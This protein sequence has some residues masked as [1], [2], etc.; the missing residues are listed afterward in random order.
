[1][2]ET[3][4]VTTRPTT[5]A[6]QAQ[7]QRRET[8]LSPPVDIC[9]NADGILLIADMPGVTRDTLDIQVDKNTLVIEGD[10]KLDMP[11]GIRALYADVRSTRYRRSFGLSSE[12]DMENIDAQLSNGVLTLKIPK[13]AELKPRKIEIRSE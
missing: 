8:V 1:M 12:L 6:Q 9:E 11:E 2:A 3:T 5:E 10:A 13:R 4:E 7:P